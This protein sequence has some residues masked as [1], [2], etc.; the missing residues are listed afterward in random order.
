MKNQND[1]IQKKKFVESFDCNDLCYID[2]VKTK[3]NSKESKEMKKD[4][5]EALQKKKCGPCDPQN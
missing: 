1:K 5:T 3:D 2:S 4:V